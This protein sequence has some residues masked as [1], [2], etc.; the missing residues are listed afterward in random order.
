MSKMKDLYA[1][2]TDLYDE[3]GLD[4][5]EIAAIT[6]VPQHIVEEIVADFE[7]QLDEVYGEA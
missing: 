2:I 3:Q 1:E 4:A 7:L 5:E 6:S